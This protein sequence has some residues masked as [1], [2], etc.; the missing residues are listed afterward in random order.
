[1]TNTE[2][3]YAKPIQLRVSQAERETI[4]AG[5]RAAELSVSEF[6]RGAA[7]DRARRQGPPR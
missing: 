1:M 4:E 7:L 6:V 2:A 3:R 5:A